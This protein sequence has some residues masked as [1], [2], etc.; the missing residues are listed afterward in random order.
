MVDL[1]QIDAILISSSSCMLALPYIT[2]YTGFKGVIY[3]TEPTLQIARYDLDGWIMCNFTS[4]S[5]VFQSYQ[6]SGRVIMKGLVQWNPLI[7]EKTST[8]SIIQI[9]TA[10]LAG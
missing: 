4:S 8:S 10:S 9:C 2:E 7:V 3:A 1:S 6:D 5:T